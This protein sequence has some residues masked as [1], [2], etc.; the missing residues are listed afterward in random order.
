MKT[1]MSCFVI[2][3]LIVSGLCVVVPSALASDGVLLTDENLSEIS[4]CAISAKNDGIVW[5]HNDS[6]DKARVYA[7]NSSTGNTVGTVTLKGVKASD[8]EDMSV[9]KNRLYIGDIGDNGAKRKNVQVHSV[10]EP[11]VDATQVDQKWTL[12]AS[13]QVLTYEGGARDAEALLVDPAGALVVVTKSAGEVMRA[14]AKNVFRPVARTNLPLVTGASMEPDGK[15]VLIRTYI[16]VFRFRA[17]S[18]KPFDALWAAK[19]RIV[20]APGLP[21]AEAVCVAPNGKSAFTITEGRGGTLRL[22]KLS[23]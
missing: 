23:L 9:A 18:G 10:A 7:V 21:Q 17:P 6:G 16:G 22:V 8:F 1:L 2:S 12:K 5:V 13:T 20:P 4:G 15:G 11:V 3:G 19:P 14:D